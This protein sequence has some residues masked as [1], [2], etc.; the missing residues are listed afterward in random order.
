MLF[1]FETWPSTEPG[2]HQLGWVTSEPQ[3]P[4]VSIT[5]CWDYRCAPRFY[6]AAGDPNPGSYVYLNTLLLSHRPNTDS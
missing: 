6:M 2:A 3:G 4:P 1:S 5:R